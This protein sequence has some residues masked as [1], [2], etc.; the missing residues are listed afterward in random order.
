MVDHGNMDCF[1]DQGVF[2]S[3]GF[4]YRNRL[5]V[6]ALASAVPEGGAAG[7][8]VFCFLKKRR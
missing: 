1:G 8:S 2:R 4:S 5:R 7:E 3:C 6:S